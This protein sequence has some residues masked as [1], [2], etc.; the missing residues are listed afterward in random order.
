M[1]TR[2]PS[3]P[4]GATLR[5]T[6]TAGFRLDVVRDLF[7]PDN[8]V[9]AD[10]WGP[11]RRLLVVRDDMAAERSEPLIGYLRAA[12][13]RGDLDDFY[14]VDADA[15]AAGDEPRV[16]GVGA[17][18]YV[19]EAA[20][21]AQLGRRDAVVAFGGERT[22]RVVAVAAASFRRHTA[23]VRVHRDLAAVV[24]C[25]R[26]GLRAALDEEGITA[27]ARRTHVIVDEEGVLA[28]PAE[29]VALLSLA[30]LDPQLLDRLDRSDVD[31]CQADALSAVLRL[32]Q[33]LGPGHP[34][35]RNGEAWLPL[36]PT[37]LA[38]PERRAWSLLTAAR[39]AH[40]LGRLPAQAVRALDGLA[41]RLALRPA[42]AVDAATAQRWVAN[43]ASGDGTV[44]LTLPTADSAGEPVTVDR[45]ALARALSD[46]ADLSGG[47]SRPGRAT[48]GALS[49]ADLTAVAGLPSRGTGM[50]MGTQLRVDVPANFPVRF[51][52]EVLA[53]HGAAL[54]DLLPERCQV[55]AVVDPYAPDQVDRVHRLLSG[56]RNR[57]YLA[58]FTV[59]PITATEHTKNLTQVATVLRVAEGLGLGGDD[60]LLVVGGGTLM[61]VV[62]YAA[63][64]YRGDTPYIR[65][66]T[67]LVGMVDAG[68]G[69]KV[70]VNLNG[71]KN[72]LGAYHPPLACLCDT[73]FLRTLAPAELRCGLAEVI[74]M[75]VVCD[76]ELFALVERHHADVLAARDTPQVREILDRAIGAMLRQLSANPIEENLRRL[77]DFGH[78]FGH[79]LESMSGYRLRH[80]EAVAIGMALS[81]YL[82]FRTGYLGRT[83]LDRLLALLR[84][85]G[86]ALWNPVCD[87]AALWR[88][89]Q[90]EVVPHK[91]GW[92]HL[93]VPR[94]I[95]VGDF[96]DSIDEI[97]AD[98]VAD[99]CAELAARTH[100]PG[101]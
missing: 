9:L 14:C 40:R 63:Y 49:D 83:D 2:V 88:R 51:T 32:C 41:E 66:P 70:G 92:L 67:T 48:R 17:C 27:L 98:L 15:G 22:G 82:A 64:L 74:K 84:R 62:G 75:A 58:R 101:R 30:V 46:Q 71:H 60:R 95:G 93:V 55:L 47:S 50:V 94:R 99:A 72:L 21:K 52:D 26:D 6:I 5:A 59:L 96:I 11:A 45:A 43:A 44:T 81:S 97:S 90:G 28:R 36:A 79:A 35:W 80:G 38:E 87:P 3:A 73:A 1:V 34:A 57:G 12:Q 85:T 69:L 8:P 53:P 31:G 39:V 100:G 56:C 20:V 29:R 24:G 4:A 65:V 42:A 10:A 54:A 7:A 33:R 25:L 61:D 91:A 19:V 77:P 68:V 18:G 76:A 78:E 13:R 37:A 86:L 16:A 89:L 23:A